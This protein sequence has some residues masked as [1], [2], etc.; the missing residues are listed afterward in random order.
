MTGA[1]LDTGAL[2]ALE[3]GS[4]RMAVLVEEALASGAE[5][6]IPA[7]V[8][9]QAWRGGAGQARIARLMRASVTS[10]VA[11]DRRQALRVGA[12]CA[13]TGVADVVD[14]SVALCARDRGHR[15]VSSDPD[16]IRAADPSLTVLSPS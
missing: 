15:V 2:I 9:A 8:V 14:V 4:R 7:G 11:L 1:T 16:D 12:R 3:S 5:L 13:A 6:A 10:I